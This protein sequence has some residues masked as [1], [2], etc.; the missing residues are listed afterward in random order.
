M[1][2]ASLV[3]FRTAMDHPDAVTRLVV[4]DGLPVVEHLERLNEAFVRDLVAL[5]VSRPDREAGGAGHQ[6]RSGRLVPDSVAGRDGRGQSRRRL[7]R[8]ARSGRR[9]RHV[10]GLPGGPAHRSRARGSRPG[11]GPP[12]RLPDAAAG[13]DRGRHRHPWRPRGDLATLGGRRAAQ[14]PIHSGHHQAEQAPDEL[15]QALATFLS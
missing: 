2:A 14:P 15:A 11:R 13:R 8:A 1:T 6:R 4:M 9:A 10:R 5:V 7:G 12:D 3:A